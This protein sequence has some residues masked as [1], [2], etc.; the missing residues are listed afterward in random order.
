MG[1]SYSTISNQLVIT[2][3]SVQSVIKKFKQFG[4]TEDL[5]G[6]GRKPKLSPRTA[7]KVCHLVNIKLRIV[8]KDIIKSLDMM[9][10]SLSTCTIRLNRN[11]FYGN[12]PRHTLFTNHVLPSRLGLKNTLTAHLQRGKTPPHTQRV[13]RIWH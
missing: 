11:R 2:R 4:T 6:C 10:V 8:L 12:L 9:G 7:Q 1:N 3:S 5:A 13:S